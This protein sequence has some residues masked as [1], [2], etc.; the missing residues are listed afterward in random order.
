[1]NDPYTF[2][3]VLRVALVAIL[4][5]VVLQVVFVSRREMRRAASSGGVPTRAKPAVGYLIVVDSGSTGLVPGSRIPIEPVTTIGRSPTS[6]IVLETN[7]ISTEH[8]RI[9]YKGNT[10]WVEDMNSRNGTLVDSAKI[11]QPVAVRPGSTLQVGDV[12]FKFAAP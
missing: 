9:L 7:Y 1:M 12:R 3:L 2:L 4:Y 6:T 5:L 11:T 10:L 8:T